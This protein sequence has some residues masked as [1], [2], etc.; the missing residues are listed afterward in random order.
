MKD[1]QPD[2]FSFNNEESKQI[3]EENNFE[4]INAVE[5]Q[6]PSIGEVRK[7]SKLGG[8]GVNSKNYKIFSE[9][10]TYTYKLWGAKDP[11]RISEVSNI[12]RFLDSK[13]ISVPVPIK[14]IKGGDYFH[15]NEG[16]V[17]L[18]TFTE[19][20]I[21]NPTTSDLPQYFDSTSELFE[22]LRLYETSDQHQPTFEVNPINLENSIGHGLNSKLF[23]IENNL[24]EGYARLTEIYPRILK[25]MQSFILINNSV[26]KQLA[27]FDLHPRNILKISPNK[28]GFLD[29]E[30]CGYMNP[31]TAWGFTLIKIL[32]QTVAGSRAT[33]DPSKLGLKALETIGSTSFGNR[34]DVL[35]LPLFGRME[36][37]RRLSFIIDDYSNNKSVAWL[38]MLTIQIQLLKESYLLF[39]D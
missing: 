23:W 32:R 15:G 8:L 4:I 29:F 36:I 26:D 39:E 20:Q 37:L 19:G 10:G 11:L 13:G 34:L 12:S 5:S 25:D 9:T 28:F 31:H 1:F 24:Q 27:H 17:S 7:T 16:L 18:L 14:S 21:Y 6:F 35:S 30:A 2:F 3:E 22:N 33:I 38:P